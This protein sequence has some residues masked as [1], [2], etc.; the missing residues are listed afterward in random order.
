M[1]T[2][3]PPLGL[4]GRGKEL[5]LELGQGLHAE[6]PLTGAQSWGPGQF[7]VEGQR[8]MTQRSKAPFP[9]FLTFSESVEELQSFFCFLPSSQFDLGM[10]YLHSLH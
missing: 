4:Q 8:K 3:W 7:D 6:G 1:G 9:P 10:V 5:L 2:L